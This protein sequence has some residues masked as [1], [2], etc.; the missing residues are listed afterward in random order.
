MPPGVT[1]LAQVSGTSDCDAD[2]V[3][4]R[5]HYD[6]YYVT[7]RSWLLDLRTIVRTLSVLFTRPRNGSPVRA[8]ERGERPTA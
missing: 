8:M 6:L 4:R 1:G 3:V 5:V 2:G 7:H